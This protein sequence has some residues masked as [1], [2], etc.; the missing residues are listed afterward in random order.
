[1]SNVMRS[2]ADIP[3]D[4]DEGDDLPEI[5]PELVL[6]DPAGASGA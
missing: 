2:V 6:I 3:G 4:A 5:S 1:M